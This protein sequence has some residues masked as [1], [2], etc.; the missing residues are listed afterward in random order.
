MMRVL[1]LSHTAELGGATYALVEGVEALSELGHE[2]DVV[3]PKEGSL[4]GRLARA[5]RVLV[6]GTNRWVSRQSP[7]FL[8]GTRQVAFDLL[9][10]TPALCRGARERGVDVVVT[11]TLSSFVGGVVARK[12]NIPHI[13]YLHEF[14]DL[15]HEYRFVWGKR[16]SFMMMRGLAT[17][18]LVN[19]NAL[20]R[21]FAK[22][23]GADRL[24]VVPYAVDVARPEADS[25]S[26]SSRIP[27]RV[28]QVGTRSRAKGQLDAVRAV[29]TLIAK[30]AKV[31]LDLVGGFDPA[32]D[33]ILEAEIER[34]GLWHEVRLVDFDPDR[35]QRVA[36]ADIA[37]VCSPCEAFGRF[38]VEA[39][40]LGKPVVGAAGGAT[41]ELIRDGVNGFLYTPG[42]SN[43][44]A[45]KV[46]EFVRE[47]SLIAELGARGALW[48][49]QQ[50]N[51]TRFGRELEAVLAEA[52]EG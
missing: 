34:L 9:R 21:Y 27:L 5:R 3:M 44:L 16:L 6:Q 32:Y 29:A 22:W 39:M 41:P 43:E 23:L 28:I 49:N 33:S 47:P 36:T 45:D 12:L 24:R 18:F 42:N 8:D 19:S 31:E 30:G 14:G 25:R 7:S 1:W 15:D 13:W 17:K 40:K 52:M 46:G 20:G 51:R 35:L 10:A 48:A 2:V 38:T 50:F 4:R 26:L 11:N 37:V